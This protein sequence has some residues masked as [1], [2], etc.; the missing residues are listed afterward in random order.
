MPVICVP[1]ACHARG[2]WF[3]PRRSRQEHRNLVS[4]ATARFFRLGTFYGRVLLAPCEDDGS[5]GTNI[6]CR[7]VIKSGQAG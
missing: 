1:L 5:V 7:I 2:R 4:A 6:S 3:E